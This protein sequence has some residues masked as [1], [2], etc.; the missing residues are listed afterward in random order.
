V[1]LHLFRRGKLQR[2]KADVFSRPILRLTSKA[3]AFLHAAF[4]KAGFDGAGHEGPS[5]GIAIVQIRPRPFFAP[6]F[7]KYARPEDVSQ[8]FVHGVAKNL[9]GDFGDT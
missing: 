7:E 9:G 2:C 5:T 8:R 3:R 4:R 1:R 6:V